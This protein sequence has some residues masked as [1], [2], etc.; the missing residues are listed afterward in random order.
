[1]LGIPVNLRGLLGEF[2]HQKNQDN[3]RKFWLNANVIH[4]AVDERSVTV[5]FQTRYKPSVDGKEAG[6][7]LASTP[8]SSYNERR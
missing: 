5:D 1:M 7:L 3:L 6:S 4:S 8:S 2:L